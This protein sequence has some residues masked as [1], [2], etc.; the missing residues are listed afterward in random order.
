MRASSAAMSRFWCQDLLFEDFQP[1]A[2]GRQFSSTVRSVSFGMQ[3]SLL[4]IK[5]L[6]FRL[7]YRLSMEEKVIGSGVSTVGLAKL[8]TF[9]ATLVGIARTRVADRP[10]VASLAGSAWWFSQIRSSSGP[11]V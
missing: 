7:Q 1:F 4:L 2:Q 11:F 5:S 8:S 6:M 9:S 10:M 3:G